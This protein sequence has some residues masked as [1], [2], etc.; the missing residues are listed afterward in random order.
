VMGCQPDPRRRER[1]EGQ[2]KLPQPH[3]Y[4]E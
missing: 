2:E 1:T 3:P 4:W